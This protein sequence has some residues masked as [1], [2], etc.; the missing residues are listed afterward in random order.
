MKIRKAYFLYGATNIEIGDCDTVFPIIKEN[1]AN[2]RKRD[3][4]GVIGKMVMNDLALLNDK[5]IKT[6][7][8]TNEEV[9]SFVANVYYAT[10]YGYLKE[11][12]HNG[13]LIIY[14]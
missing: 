3:K 4:H 10:T 9:I 7:M 1:A 13:M 12:D 8:L 2:L 11:D 14:R 5:R 6:D